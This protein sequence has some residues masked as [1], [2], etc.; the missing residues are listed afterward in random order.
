M[1]RFPAET[2]ALG[3]LEINLP[4]LALFAARLQDVAGGVRPSP[5]SPPFKKG[6]EWR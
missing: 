3:R 6:L 5:V 1:D 2:G 4:G